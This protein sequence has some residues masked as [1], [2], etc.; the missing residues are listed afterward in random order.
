LQN[1]DVE[2]MVNILPGFGVQVHGIEDITR[3]R[4]LLDLLYGSIGEPD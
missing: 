4:S 2:K 1:D 3:Q